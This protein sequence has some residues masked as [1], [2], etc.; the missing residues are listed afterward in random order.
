[1]NE[2]PETKR[3]EEKVNEEAVEQAQ[4]QA[5][6]AQA[7]EVAAEP[8]VEEQ[9]AAAQAQVA[10]LQDSYLRAMAEM[11]NTR[12]RADEALERA[13]KF[14]VEKFAKNMLPVIDSLEKALEVAGDEKNPIIEGVEATYRQLV[15]AMEMSGMVEINPVGEKFDPTKHQAITMVPA[16]EGQESGH[17]AQVF[18]RG[19]LINDRV[20]RAALV[21]VVQ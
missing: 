13:H 16:M 19:W 12:R 7:E 3:E 9:L 4:A 2:H 11:E 17:V 1:M 6:A 15:K 21:S 8:S 5:E 10:T 20:L 18:Q 14:A